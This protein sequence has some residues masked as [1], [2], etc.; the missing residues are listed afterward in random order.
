MINSCDN[1]VD[2]Y[3]RTVP[4]RDLLGDEYSGDAQALFDRLGYSSVSSM[5]VLGKGDGCA[6]YFGSVPAPTFPVQPTTPGEITC[7]RDPV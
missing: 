1:Y 4:L 6:I 3:R 7:N 5:A 2:N